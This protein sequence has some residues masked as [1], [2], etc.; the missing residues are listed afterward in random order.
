MGMASPAQP[1]ITLTINRGGPGGSRGAECGGREGASPQCAVD[2]VLGPLPPFT[3]G[4]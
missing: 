3:V 4:G 1:P 2:I